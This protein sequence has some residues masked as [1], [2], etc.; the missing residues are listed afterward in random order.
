MRWLALV[1]AGVA[2]LWPETA[3]AQTYDILGTR[4]AGMG[5][6]FVAVADDA[7]AV[8]WNPGGLASGAFFSLLVDYGT[9]EAEPGDVVRLGSGGRS[10]GIIALS[11]PA[12]GISYYRLRQSVVRPLAGGGYALENLITHHSGAT[13]VQSLTEHVAVGTTLKL[14]RGVAATAGSD[15]PGP[16]PD[17]VVGR[18]S[19][20]FDADA[21]LM[22]TF[23]GFRAGLSVRNLT[24]PSFDSLDLEDALTLDRQARA[25]ISYLLPSGLL[26][27]VDADLTKARGSLGESRVIAAGAEARLTRR[28]FA[29]AGV[30]V[31]T[32]EPPAGRTPAVALGGS[33]A[34]TAAV[35]VDGQA[36]LGASGAD[37]GWGVA[38]RL[39]F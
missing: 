30:R 34:A 29:R 6:A 13:L 38:A 8:Y 1:V 39:V 25:G 35:F 36:T 17:D 24:E 18:A 31:N 33:Y 7:S 4:A 20:H 37:R 11:M 16:D 32:L 14:V 22:A 2:A 21:G 23:G 12:L 5:G 15:V 26:V 9:G 19:S 3:T 28:L 27:A 10:A